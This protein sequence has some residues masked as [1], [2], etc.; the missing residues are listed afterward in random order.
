MREIKFRAY[1]EISNEVLGM[2]Y[3]VPHNYNNTVMQYTGLKDKNGKEIFEGDIVKVG[4]NEWYAKNYFFVEQVF[5][6]YKGVMFGDKTPYGKQYSSSQVK[7][8]REYYYDYFEII[9]NVYEN[10]ELLD[11]PHN[12]LH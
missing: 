6:G 5:F 1:T 10:P 4:N 7:G 11:K 9:G 12:P 8:E 2:K 3:D